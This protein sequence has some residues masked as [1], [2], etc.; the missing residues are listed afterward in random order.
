[1]FLENKEPARA[2]EKRAAARLAEKRKANEAL[3]TI[4]REPSRQVRRRMELLYWKMMRSQKKAE[5]LR[6]RKYPFSDIRPVGDPI[7]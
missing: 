1:M 5:E 3:P 6:K 2:G 7:A 4:D